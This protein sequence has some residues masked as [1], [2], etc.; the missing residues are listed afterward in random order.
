MNWLVINQITKNKNKNKNEINYG[1]KL[2][3]HDHFVIRNSFLL[4]LCVSSLICVQRSIS[5]KLLS[6]IHTY[7]GGRIFRVIHSLQM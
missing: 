6:Y 3:V 5:I 7:L 4:L 2:L 1:N